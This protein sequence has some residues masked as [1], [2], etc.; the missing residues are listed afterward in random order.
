MMPISLWL[1]PM[2]SEHGSLH[3]FEQRK[4]HAAGGLRRRRRGPLAPTT[5]PASAVGPGLGIAICRQL[6]GPSGVPRCISPLPAIWKIA[7]APPPAE[8]PI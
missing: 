7:P 5:S 6:Q 3:C 8:P 4:F 1:K 2:G